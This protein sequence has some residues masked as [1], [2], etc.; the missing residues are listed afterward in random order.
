MS[1]QFWLSLVF[2]MYQKALD[3][4]TQFTKGRWIAFVALTVCFLLRIVLKQACSVTSVC[5]KD[6]FR[7]SEYY[8]ILTHELLIFN[9]ITAGLV[10]RNVRAVHL[11]PEPPARLPHAQ[12]RPG[13][14]RAGCR[15]RY[16][17]LRKIG[18]RRS[19]IISGDTEE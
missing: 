12:D 4:S 15:R 10:H 8:F 2:Q 16:V 18:L 14:G 19:W 3:E 7:R 13:N 6:S 1:R 5:A 9:I 11:S 17:I